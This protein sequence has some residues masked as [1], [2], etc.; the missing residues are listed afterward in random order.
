MG[1][2]VAYK[3]DW[4]FDSFGHPP[5]Q[6]LENYGLKEVVDKRLQKVNSIFCGYYCILFI[7]GIKPTRENIL[8]LFQ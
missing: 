4:Y 5:I 3:G 7:L 8:K 2:F 1:H 6:E